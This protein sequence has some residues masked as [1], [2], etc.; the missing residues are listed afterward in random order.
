MAG[1]TG[2]GG[3]LKQNTAVTIQL[4]PFIDA[5]GVGAAATGLTITPSECKLSKNGGTLAA[6]NEATNLAHDANGMYKALLDATDTNTVGILTIIPADTAVGHQPFSQNYM[7]L[8]ANVYDSLMGTDNLEIDV[9]QVAGAAVNTASAQL[10][11]NVV[12]LTSGAITAAALAA[13]AIGASELAADAAAEI[14]TAVVTALQDRIDSGAVAAG[15]SSSVT[16]AAS[17]SATND[18]YK[19]VFIISASGVVQVGEVTAYNGTTKVA[20]VSPAWDTVPDTAY[21]YVAIGV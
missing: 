21:Q 16:L 11:V 13:D 19:L 12:S 3:F 6:K 5:T 20:T 17:A 7:V 18:V 15:G 14:A 8:P 4:G 9:K 1:Q 2:F 10:G